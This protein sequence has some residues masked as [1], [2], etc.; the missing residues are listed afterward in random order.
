MLVRGI[1]N[2]DVSG[3]EIKLLY[4]AGNYLNQRDS[5]IKHLDQLK[6]A[7]VL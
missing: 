2:Y 4:Y 1:E 3:I 7:S 5:A 6:T